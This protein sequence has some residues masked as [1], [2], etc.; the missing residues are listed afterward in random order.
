[1][2]PVSTILKAKPSEGVITV[3]P[4]STVGEAGR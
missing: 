3:P 2:M 1:M 4:G